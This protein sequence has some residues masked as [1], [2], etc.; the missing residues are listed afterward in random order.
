MRIRVVAGRFGGRI[1]DAPDRR[2]THAMSERARGALFNILGE[3]VRGAR[4]LDAFAGSGAVG[5]EALSRGSTSAV[6][7]E[8]D[9]IAA[10][11]I[12]KNCALL[13]L[14]ESTQI[15]RAT[16]SNWLAT[17]EGEL[18]DLIFADPPYHNPQVATITR[19]VS[20]LK[21]DG[22]LVVSHPEDVELSFDYRMVLQGE[23]HYSA[24]HL[25]IFKRIK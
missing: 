15:V 23:R 5:I 11:I 10:H 2:N 12:A 7:V 24:A 8:R 13:G 19:L 18:F 21:L 20:H 6:F 17:S 1:L 14:E 22:L 16:V 4:I 25:S 3:K 9:Q